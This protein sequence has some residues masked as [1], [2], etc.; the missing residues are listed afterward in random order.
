MENTL[1][2]SKKKRFFPEIEISFDS[3]I[4]YAIFLTI[5]GNLGS[6]IYLS[7]KGTR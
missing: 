7:I 3:P 2:G 5:H 6:G 1:P 4:S